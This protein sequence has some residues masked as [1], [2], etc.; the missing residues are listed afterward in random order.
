MA[1]RQCPICEAKVPAGWTVAFTDSVDCPSCGKRLEVSYGNRGVAVLA[2]LAAAMLAWRFSSPGQGMLSF[3]LPMVYSILAFGVVTPL[4]QMF[5]ADL[6][7]KEE[8]PEP[9]PVASHGGGHH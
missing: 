7:V 5:I 9:A 6:V 8:E 2:G 3:V 4:A 1:A